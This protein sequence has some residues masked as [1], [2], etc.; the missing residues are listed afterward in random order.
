[1]GKPTDATTPL[2]DNACAGALP[3]TTNPEAPRNGGSSSNNEPAV[4]NT[5]YGFRP[6]THD[7]EDDDDELP[8]LYSDVAES[9]A[10]IP[11]NQYVQQSL[12][13]NGPSLV[14][15]FSAD[16]GTKNEYYMSSDLDS[17]PTLLEQHVL[18]WSKKPP[19]TFIQVLGSH[20]E[21]RSEN[22]GSNNRTRTVVDFRVRVDMTPYLYTDLARGT[23]TWAGLRTVDNDEKVKRGT[24]LARR[25]PGARKRHRRRSGMRLEDAGDSMGEK[26]TLTEWCHRYCASSAGLKVFCLQR[27]VVGIDKD[28]LIERLH[29]LVRSTNYRGNVTISFPTEGGRVEV[30]N[31]CKVNEWRFKTWIRLLTFFTL[32]ILLTFPYLFFRTKRFETVVAEWPF[33]RPARNGSTDREYASITEDQ[34]YGL[35]GAAIHAAVINRRQC[36]LDQQDLANS[37]AQPQGV[38]TGIHSILATGIQAMNVVDQQFGWGA[39]T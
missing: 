39:N 25:A 23:S 27:K 31:D 3:L 29:G 10:L 7:H 15:V 28:L 34:L 5:D 19:R 38:T 22:G 14:P 36:V 6:R 11:P 18:A 12:S 37:H 26:P 9:S 17:D 8:P 20:T 35:W 24:S 16:S 30:Y 21:T 33:S 32:T 4:D 1:M 2:A 13:P